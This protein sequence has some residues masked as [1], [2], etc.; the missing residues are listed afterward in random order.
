MLTELWRADG[1][2]LY[3]GDIED[4]DAD[5]ALQADGPVDVVWTDPPWNAGIARRM[6]QWADL[7]RPVDLAV[8][9]AATARLCATVGHGFVQVGEGRPAE[10]F[11]AALTRE[12]LDC[13]VSACAQLTRDPGRGH[14]RERAEKV[15]YAER[16]A[17]VI[18]FGRCR[19]VQI[20]P[21]LA[22]IE[23]T[24]HCLAA[25]GAR[26][27]I[28]PFVGYG[29]TLRAAHPIGARVVGVDLNADRAIEAATRYTA[30]RNL[31]L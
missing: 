24:G 4:G 25:A 14:P 6:R 31:R 5:T 19:H 12:G 27:V 3:A 13:T 20:P 8:L 11:G 7:D 26:S 1:H 2:V 21:G 28:D 17:R 30:D 9:A 23:L 22:W 16:E 10:T 18:G 15:G 29:S